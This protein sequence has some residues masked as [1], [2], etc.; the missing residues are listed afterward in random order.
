MNTYDVNVLI[1]FRMSKSSDISENVIIVPTTWCTQL[2]YFKLRDI[3]II[4]I[5]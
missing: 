1:L 5:T 4:Y 2:T 3:I